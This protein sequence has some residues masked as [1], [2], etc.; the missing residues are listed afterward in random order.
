MIDPTKQDLEK[1]SSISENLDTSEPLDDSLDLNY[2]QM[3]DEVWHFASMDRG[4]RCMS[5]AILSVL[6]LGK[7]LNLRHRSLFGFQ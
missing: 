1:Q 6:Y 4:K 2:Y 5:M 3:V 7:Y